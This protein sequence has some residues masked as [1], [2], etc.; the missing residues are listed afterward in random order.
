MRIGIIGAGMIGG[1]LARRLAAL[2]H[3]VALSNSRGPDT[4]RS[5]AAAARPVTAEE[6]ACSAWVADAS[7]QKP[8]STSA[9]RARW[10]DYVRARSPR[11]GCGHDARGGHGRRV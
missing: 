3:E 10:I 9:H 11:L 1:T 6:A 8:A 4:L 5:L 2:G 7:R